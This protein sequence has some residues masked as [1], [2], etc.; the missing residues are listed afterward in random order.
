MPRRKSTTKSNSRSMQTRAPR[1]QIG[2][3]TYDQVRALVDQSGMAIG[4]AIEEVAKSSGRT[5]GTVAVT[6]YRLSKQKSGTKAPRNGRRT[7]TVAQAPAA[8]SSSLS[9][10]LS[11]VAADLKELQSVIAEQAQEMDRLRQESKLAA[12]IRKAMEG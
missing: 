9:S 8:K 2:Q 10:I 7:R 3:Q 11:R 1:G 12:R 4:K 6:Y 5:P